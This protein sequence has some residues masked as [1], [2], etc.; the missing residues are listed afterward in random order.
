M[1]DSI[2][3]LGEQGLFVR[4]RYNAV[5]ALT[6]YELSL[7]IGLARQ[8]TVKSG[9]GVTQHQ[10]FF[11][12]MGAEA[13]ASGVWVAPAGAPPGWVGVPETGDLIE[14]GYQKIT[15]KNAMLRTDWSGD[16]WI[17]QGET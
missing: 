2:E 13:L 11:V 4:E 3:N 5:G 1:S 7:K 16:V 14:L 15:L 9:E 17:C 10:R 12:L 6:R 8:D